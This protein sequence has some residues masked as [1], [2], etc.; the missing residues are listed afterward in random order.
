MLGLCPLAGAAET[1]RQINKEFGISA[2]FPSGSRV[3]PSLSGDH[4]HGFYA[5]YHGPARTCDEMRSSRIDGSISAIGIYA[6]YNAAF[7]SVQANFDSYCKTPDVKPALSR[8]ELRRLSIKGHRVKACSARK[9]GGE[10]EVT[11][12]TQTGKQSENGTSDAVPTV[13]Y[14]AS[15]VTNV[16]HLKKDLPMFEAFLRDLKIESGQPVN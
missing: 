12:V 11:V 3:C 8:A 2:V 14:V 4:P 1:G 9:L 13:F 10:I 6:S 15:L 5:Q 16:A 7:E